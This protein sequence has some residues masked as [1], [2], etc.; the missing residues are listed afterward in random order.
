MARGRLRN[1]KDW[2]PRSRPK[3]VPEITVNDIFSILEALAEA[4]LSSGEAAT[5]YADFFNAWDQ[6]AL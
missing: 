4:T 1:G 2:C 5:M 6:E 3:L